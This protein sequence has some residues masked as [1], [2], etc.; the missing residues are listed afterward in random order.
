MNGWVKLHRSTQDHWIWQD[1]RYFK[2]WVTILLNVNHQ[3]N[4]FP[5][6]N[7]VHT[8][9]PGQSFRTLEQWAQ[10]FGT[11]KKGTVNF[12]NLLENDAM[13]TREILGKGNRRK[14]LLSVVNWEKYQRIGTESGTG[15]GT[16]NGTENGTESDPLTRMN[17]K[18]KN[19]NNDENVFL[20]DFEKKIQPVF[21]RWIKYNKQQFRTTLA[22][23]TQ[24]EQLQHLNELSAGDT[25]V[26]TQ[27]VR[28]AIH[29]THKHF[30]SLQKC[31]RNGS[32]IKELAGA[33]QHAADTIK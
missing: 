21:I 28:Q 15:S 10:L 25:T 22:P 26:A 4:K 8:C 19:E 29:G 7:E 11:N 5:V 24:R 6:G 27:I 32:E 30:I 18:E 31:K 1:N 20:T 33:A 3:A 16:E 9:N 12:M 23:I 13:I 14:T 17:K 2:W